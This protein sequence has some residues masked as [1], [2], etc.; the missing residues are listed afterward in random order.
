MLCCSFH[1]SDLF[2]SILAASPLTQSDAFLSCYVGSRSILS[3]RDLENEL[4]QILQ[5]FC[6]PS[7][8]TFRKQNHDKH[9]EQHQQL[10]QKTQQHQGQVE[11]W[12]PNEIDIEDSDDPIICKAGDENVKK[13]DQLPG[14]CCFLDFGIGPLSLHPIVSLYFPGGNN[15][16]HFITSAD[17]LDSLASY[18]TDSKGSS[19]TEL[20]LYLC[21]EY[22]VNSLSDIGIILNGNLKLEMLMIKHIHAARIKVLTEI[23]KKHIEEYA[24]QERTIRESYS[25]DGHRSKKKND[26]S[27]RSIVGADVEVEKSNTS[28]TFR[29]GQQNSSIIP[30]ITV[31]SR[32]MVSE[33]ISRCGEILSD[34]TYS[35]SFT[36]VLSVVD[37]ICRES[38]KTEETKSTTSKKRARRKK[39]ENNDSDSNYNDCNFENI[40]SFI[41]DEIR[42]H[43]MPANENGTTI[44]ISMDTFNV[45][46]E[47]CAEHIMLHYG[48]DKYRA[49]RLTYLSSSQSEI[50]DVVDVNEGENKVNID[51]EDIDKGRKQ[52]EITE[53]P[54]NNIEVLD[55]SEEISPSSDIACEGGRLMLVENPHDTG[56]SPAAASA[57]SSENASVTKYDSENNQLT[58]HGSVTD[59]DAGDVMDCATVAG[60]SPMVPLSGYDV[61]PFECKMFSLS[62]IIGA[63]AGG[64]GGGS[65]T[66]G[67][68]TNRGL[69][70]RSYDRKNA[71]KTVFVIP[72]GEL[73]DITPWGAGLPVGGVSKGATP[74][75]VSDLRAVGR[76][77]EALV[78]QY[79]LSKTSG[80]VVNWV[81]KEEESRAGYDIIVEKVQIV[82]SS[83]IGSRPSSVTETSY[84]EVKTTRFDDLN[85]FEISLWEW[86]FATANPRVK[87]HIYRVFNAGDPEKVRIVVVEDIL[88]MITLKKVRLCLNI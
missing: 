5:S 80:E 48:G 88:E 49:K 73:R 54:K 21:T 9:L 51:K 84:I 4:V 59:A 27:Q 14:S 13:N 46:R 10:L 39:N 23:Q 64:A 44:N 82:A 71:A 50:I 40:S 6:I 79:L 28:G 85:T 2:L 58:C 15:A 67:T 3:Y 60:K 20:E 19:I 70:Q 25:F 83:A 36:K 65:G 74:L 37:S 43:E 81:N 87:Y 12:D 17:I 32:P 56:K 76:W 7:I 77:G 31:S 41:V 11:E 22:D 75:D 42:D 30:R 29:D 66:G 47:V 52:G 63:G 62:G 78:Y 26:R 86:E 18:D 1:D 72:N 55:A 16:E 8:T 45:L 34:N 61:A 35:P 57:I 33:F 24:L 68:T 69:L 38:K 53:C